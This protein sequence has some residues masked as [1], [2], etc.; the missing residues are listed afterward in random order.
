MTMWR[1]VNEI[2]YHLALM[3]T[4]WTKDVVLLTSGP[5]SFDE[6]TIAKLKKAGVVIDSRP[7]LGLE[8]TGAVDPHLKAIQFNDGS[9]SL[10]RKAVLIPAIPKQR[11]SSSWITSL[12]LIMNEQMGTVSVDKVGRTS[13][14]MIWA[15]GDIAGPSPSVAAAMGTGSVSG[16]TLASELYMNDFEMPF[17]LPPIMAGA[18]LPFTLAHSGASSL[19]PTDTTAATAAAAAVPRH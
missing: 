18:F 19:P 16:M 6:A 7:I 11:A 15:I 12:G 14:P 17:M 9:P 3:L 4:Q 1:C 10:E 5:P 2:G 13:Q 8:T